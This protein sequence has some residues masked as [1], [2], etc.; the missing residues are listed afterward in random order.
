MYRTG[1]RGKWLPDGTIA[2]S[3][4]TPAPPDPP[5]AEA[6][7]PIPAY[8][9]PSG[10]MEAAVAAI[11][12]EVLKVERVGR[13]DNFFELKGHSLLAVQIIARLRHALGVEVALDDLLDH[14]ILTAFVD[15]L[16]GLQLEQF[17]EHELGT[18]LK[19]IRERV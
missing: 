4:H 11:W 17:N 1:V 3:V 12:A 9:A 7:S 10:E 15:R 13:W 6:E 14:P 18:V 19:L 2:L 8:E 16:V 5:T